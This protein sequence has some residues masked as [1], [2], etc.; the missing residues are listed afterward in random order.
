MPDK[1]LPNPK[2]SVTLTETTGVT[3]GIVKIPQ[4]H[5]GALNSG[6]TP[7]NAGGG[8]IPQAFKDFLKSEIRENATSRDA[9]VKASQDDKGRNFKAAWDLAADYDD[10]KPAEK[11]E[12]S[13]EL[14][15]RVVRDP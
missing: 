1:G 3:T 8:R 5:G 6:G 13:G 11:K 9:L 14:V 2:Q 4:P 15:I 10:E 12:L 7:G